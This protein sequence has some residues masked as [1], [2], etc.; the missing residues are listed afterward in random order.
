MEEPVSSPTPTITEEEKKPR[1]AVSKKPS[2][3]AQAK[4]KA[5]LGLTAKPSEANLHSEVRPKKSIIAH[6][7]NYDLSPWQKHEIRNQSPA[8]QKEDQSSPVKLKSPTRT[9]D[10][11]PG[12]KGDLPSDIFTQHDSLQK[13]QVAELLQTNSE[14][15][16]MR[17]RQLMEASELVRS[18][19]Q[20]EFE[21]I[22]QPYAQVLSRKKGK[23]AGS[24]GG[25]AAGASPGNRRRARRK[26]KLPFREAEQ[27]KYSDQTYQLR[28][29]KSNNV[30]IV[31]DDQAKNG[32]ALV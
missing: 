25:Q 12:L 29:S 18:K 22:R 24:M 6:L 17:L 28:S 4:S 19:D 15:Q 20:E 8:Q 14:E 27:F 7:T 31:L 30:L 32:E 2:K 26:S 23:Q 13:D 10:P 11:N 21:N 5:K 16:E 3:L 1:K 9:S